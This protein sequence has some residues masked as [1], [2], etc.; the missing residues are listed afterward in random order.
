MGNP[1]G[2]IVFKVLSIGI[3]IPVGIAARKGVEKAWLAARPAD[4]PRKAKDPATGW[5]DAI[6]WAALS[7]VGLA[8]AELVTYQGAA[9]A[10]RA[11][12]GR[13]PPA[14]QDKADQ[15]RAETAA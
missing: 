7:G 1:T 9:K 4:P 3:G 10:Y 2:K 13:R 14:E 8:I 11:L 6:A 12:T 5:P 15:D